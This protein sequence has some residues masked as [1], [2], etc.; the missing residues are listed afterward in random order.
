MIYFIFLDH[1]GNQVIEFCSF[2]LGLIDPKTEFVKIPV[3]IFIAYPGISGPYP[4][5]HLV[6]HCMDCLKVQSLITFYLCNVVCFFT[7]GPI[8]SPFISRHLSL[9]AY[10]VDKKCTEGTGLKNHQFS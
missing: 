10:M 8:T 9:P 1:F 3:Q 7:Y 4:G 6:Y 2:A 5:F